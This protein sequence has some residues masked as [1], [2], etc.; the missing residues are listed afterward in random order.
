MQ[1]V[2]CNSVNISEGGMALS[3]SFRSAP[4]KALMFSSPCR[5]TKLRIGRIDDL[6]VENGPSRSSLRIPFAR[7]QIRAT[8]LAI[9]KA[10]RDVAGVGC[11][12]VSERRD[13]FHDELVR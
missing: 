4:E 2:R 3:T 13:L 8:E 9:T 11:T 10:G 12:T 5:V 7:T 1:E 6:L